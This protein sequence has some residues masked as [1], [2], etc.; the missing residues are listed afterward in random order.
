VKTKQPALHFL[1]S[2]YARRATLHDGQSQYGCCSV[3]AICSAV[4]HSSQC[5]PTRSSSSIRAEYADANRLTIV[6]RPTSWRPPTYPSCW[7][8][9]VSCSTAAFSTESKAVF[10]AFRW[11]YAGVRSGLPRD[12]KTESKASPPFFISASATFSGSRALTYAALPSYFQ[13]NCFG[14]RWRIKRYVR[15]ITR[16]RRGC[17]EFLLRFDF[18]S[19]VIGRRVKYL[20]HNA[21]RGRRHVSRVAAPLLP[22]FGLDQRRHGQ[23]QKSHG[24]KGAHDKQFHNSQSRS[25][26]R[27]ANPSKDGLTSSPYP[28]RSSPSPKTIHYRS[29]GHRSDHDRESVA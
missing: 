29:S 14:P 28:A 24:K 26:L 2:G 23:E 17:R 6:D 27:S 4:R 19:R 7:L 1:E 16:Q 8:A 15:G 11:R 5:G 25:P 3:P 18:L 13:S 9:C 12:T 22:G 21:Y 20:V 10:T